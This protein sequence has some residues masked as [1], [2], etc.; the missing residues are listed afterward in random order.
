MV[1]EHTVS[2]LRHLPVAGAHA[3]FD[4]RE[5]LARAARRERSRKRRVGVAVDDHEVRGGL[6][7]DGLEGVHDASNLLAL[8][9]R[10]DAELPVG[11]GQVELP[12]EHRGQLVVVVLAAV[13]QQFR[14]ALAQAPRDRRRLDELRPVPDQCD[15]LHDGAEKGDVCRREEGMRV[16]TR[17]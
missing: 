13:H 2:L 7:Q 6:P 1:G 8:G 17:R 9:A 15:D 10:A 5:R 3:G 14:V 11:A 4:V 16:T 12:E